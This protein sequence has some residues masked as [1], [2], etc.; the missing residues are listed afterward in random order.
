MTAPRLA[1]AERRRH[2]Q[3]CVRVRDLAIHH[4]ELRARRREAESV[5]GMRRRTITSLLG[6]ISAYL[7]AACGGSDGETGAVMSGSGYEYGLPDGWRDASGK[8]RFADSAAQKDAFATS[9]SVDILP[10]AERRTLRE[11]V[12]DQ[13]SQV[14][15]GVENPPRPDW[16]VKA[17]RP[18]ARTELDGEKAMQFDHELVIDGERKIARRL[19]AYHRGNAYM[20]QFLG[21]A[22]GSFGDFDE[23]AAS[24]RWR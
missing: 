17:P 20:L 8:Q 6:L 2:R 12:R 24:W 18:P 10:V 13:V 21:P 4:C 5:A 19:T 15:D 14:R 11:S 3:L 7:L 1:K 9:F 16:R 22:A 23:I